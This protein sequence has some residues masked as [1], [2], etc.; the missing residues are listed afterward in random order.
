M[1]ILMCQTCLNLNWMKIYNIK[2]NFFLSPLI[3]HF[4][5]KN[6]ENLWLINNHF[7]TV[8]GYFFPNFMNIFHKTEA[9]TV[10]LRCLVRLN[11]IWIKSYYILLVKEKKI[12]VWK[13]M[14]SGLF[15]RSEFWHLRRKSAVI[16]SK[17]L[18]WQNSLIISWTT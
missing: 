1:N 8:F 11:F 16:F 13:C 6:L 4:E 17:W 5:R 10:I 2:H 3:F 18:F 7:L 12:H 9:Q 15:R 14:I